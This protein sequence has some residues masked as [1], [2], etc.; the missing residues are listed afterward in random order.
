[1]QKYLLE[2]ET[3]KEDTKKAANTDFFINRSDVL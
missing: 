3:F 1:M 2:M